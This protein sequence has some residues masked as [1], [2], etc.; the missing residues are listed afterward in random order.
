ME[1]NMKQLP[2]DNKGLQEMVLSLVMENNSLVRDKERLLTTS[3]QLSNKNSLLKKEIELLKIQLK[4]LK[5]QLYGRSS[6]K[7][8][9]KISLLE[10]SIEEKEL[11]LANSF[12]YNLD[13]IEDKEKKQPK[14]QKL[15][16]ELPREEILLEHES[17]CPSCGGEDFRRI[18]DDVSEVLEYVPSSFKVIRYVRPRCACKAC[19]KIVQA[20]EASKVID[21]GK[22]GPGLL[23]HI[24]IQKYCNHLPLYR[25][26]QIYA[27]E[28]IDLSRSTMA[29]WVGRCA[30]LLDILCDE[31]KKHVFA[32][33]GVHGDDTPV[34]VLAP[35]L[36]K[37]KLGR[38]WTYVRD[39]RP[40]GDDTPPAVC[41][42][43]S[44][45]RKGEHPVRHLKDYKGI[46]HADAY[47]GY[48]GL[49]RG[50]NNPEAKIEEA[51]C[52]AHARRKF[53][54]VAITS[55]KATI[56]SS[57]LKQISD[58]YDIER[59]VRYKSVEIRL[60][61]RQR[62][63]KDLIDKLFIGLKKDLKKLPK[64]SAT[65]KAINYALNNEIALKRFLENGK[66][67]IDNNPAERALRPIAIGRNNWTFAGSDSGGESTAVI[68][69][70]I[71]T[72]KMNGLNPWLYM[73]KVLESI[74]DYNA[75]KI[76]ELLPWNIEL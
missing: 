6:E 15:P 35:E 56:A 63:S 3:K 30:S 11:R 53:Y 52:W 10:E 59:K 42:Y 41:Y 64:K 51:A 5:S 74:Q 58:I 67:E 47:A 14:R 73:K 8:K 37:T 27:R 4:L 7:L 23:A 38:I 26:S 9:H 45:N 29:S 19:D 75:Q 25:Q 24:L 62:Y 46:L 32:A 18:G 1:L 34:K 16:E 44:P 12:D 61:Y 36:G 31:I 28:G 76:T 40:H 70:I 33:G 60:D 65:A 48:N 54:E 50:G 71:E 20:Y 43:Y 22:G 72:A 49:Y 68:Y 21:K 13:R 55:P 17:K 57:V 66:I 69:S 2:T 39:G